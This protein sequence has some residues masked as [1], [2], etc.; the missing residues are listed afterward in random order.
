ME[1]IKKNDK[2]KY[3]LML[4]SKGVKLPEDFDTDMFRTKSQH[5]E[6]QE[7]QREGETHGHEQDIL[8]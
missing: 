1:R 8:E 4:T 7:R 3:L 5:Y 2:E 6:Y